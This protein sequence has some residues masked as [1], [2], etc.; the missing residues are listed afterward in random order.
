[1]PVPSVYINVF[2]A[3]GPIIIQPGT[4][5]AAMTGELA[6]DE[7]DAPNALLLDQ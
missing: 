2:K 1:M 4:G 7:H 5:W 6:K 3:A